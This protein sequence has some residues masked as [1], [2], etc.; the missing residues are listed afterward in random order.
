MSNIEISPGKAYYDNQDQDT[1]SYEVIPYWSTKNSKGS[2]A[3]REGT[4]GDENQ[5]P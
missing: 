4:Y 1:D 5:Y 3:A 2:K